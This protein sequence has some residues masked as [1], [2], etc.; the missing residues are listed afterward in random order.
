MTGYS[1]KIS[2]QFFIQSVVICSLLS[3]FFGLLY[4]SIHSDSFSDFGRWGFGFFSV[5]TMGVCLSVHAHWM[6]IRP[7]H[8]LKKNLRSLEVGTLISEDLTIFPA[9]RL[10]CEFAE[11]ESLFH[12]LLYALQARHREVLLTKD[13]LARINSNLEAVLDLRRLQ[14][15]SRVAA[16]FQ[17]NKLHALGEMAAGIAHEINNP[18]AI[19]VGRTEQL[20]DIMGR[21]GT[22]E[23]KRESILLSM[24]KTLFRIQEAVLDLELIASSPAHEDMRK[25][26]ISRLVRRLNKVVSNRYQTQEVSFDPLIE[27]DL[28]IEGREV[29]LSQA[30]L[31]LLEN[32]SEAAQKSE[33]KWVRVELKKSSEDTCTISIIDSGCGV[34]DSL[35]EKLFQPFFSTKED[36]RGMGLNLAK[37]VI[38]SHQGS[39]D[40]DFNHDNTTVLIKLPLR[41]KQS[42]AA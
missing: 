28:E 5:I 41:Q 26:P 16:S 23:S 9:S 40:F 42:A 22:I 7:L 6:L 20:R 25:I 38:D 32:A 1:K 3:L 8:N 12:D 29:E 24:E 21:E 15:E 4:I 2:I 13:H 35:R 31:Y 10:E 34:E 39:I 37:A 14:L 33:N 17:Q 11:I 36:G 30:I 27:S 18:L 19:L